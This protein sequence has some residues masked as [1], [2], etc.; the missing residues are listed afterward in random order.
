[1]PR[2]DGREALAE[3]KAIPEL[4]RIPIVVLTTSQAEEDIL[5]AYDLGVAG[6]ITKPVSFEG[7]VE[8]MKVLCDY[9]FQIMELPEK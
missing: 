8:S 6:F 7:L 3:I 1:M 9:W 2:K 4:R 5:R